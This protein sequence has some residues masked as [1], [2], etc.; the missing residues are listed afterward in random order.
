MNQVLNYLQKYW[1]N[2]LELSGAIILCIIG[3]IAGI[4]TIIDDV[5]GT[6]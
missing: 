6:S 4:A 2:I 5:S 1:K 3:I